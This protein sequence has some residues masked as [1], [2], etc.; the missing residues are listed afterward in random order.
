MKHLGKENAEGKK[1]RKKKKRERG[2]KKKHAIFCFQELKINKFN[3][4]RK[5]KETVN[6]FTLCWVCQ[7]IGLKAM[8]EGK[9]GWVRLSEERSVYWSRVKMSSKWRHELGNASQSR[10]AEDESTSSLVAFWLGG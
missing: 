9:T 7:D 2:K 6:H 5:E 4:T 8:G 1:K 3:R 10:S